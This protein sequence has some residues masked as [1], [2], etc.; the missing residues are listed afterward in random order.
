MAEWIGQLLAGLPGWAI[1]L[2]IILIICVAGFVMWATDVYPFTTK[3]VDLGEK[4]H[5]KK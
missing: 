3:R 5:A 4:K 2:A 1:V